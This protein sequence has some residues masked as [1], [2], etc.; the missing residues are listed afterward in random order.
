M[1]Y[2]AFL[3][4]FR[5]APELRGGGELLAPVFA[6]M[7]PAAH[8]FRHGFEWC[9]GQGPIGLWLLVTGQVQKMTFADINPRS[10][11]AGED[12]ARTLGLEARADFIV[13]DNL[14]RVPQLG[15]DGFDVVV[16]NPPNYYAIM[17][18]HPMSE[19]LRAADPGWRIHTGF[20]RTIGPYLAPG[21]QL[22]IS[23]VAPWD[24]TVT[25]PGI[26]EWDH[27]PE[28]PISVFR[29]MIE[30]AGLR[31]LGCEPFQGP[32][33]T[34]MGMVRAEQPEDFRASGGASRPLEG[35]IDARSEAQPA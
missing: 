32:G 10:V 21:A 1:D 6:D 28:A 12:A 7:L 31:W 17:P 13:S 14:A 2:E 5:G 16:G 33:G 22:Y 11:A 20:Y 25:L 35:R 15:R 29:T 24:A 26:G 19:D 30:D 34:E 8:P 9:S 23:E 27:R 4:A 3:G 18:D